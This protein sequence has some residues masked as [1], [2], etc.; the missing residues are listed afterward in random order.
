MCATQW[1]Y[2]YGCLTLNVDWHYIGSV[3]ATTHQEKGIITLKSICNI[4]NPASMLWTASL[5]HW[6]RIP[7][8]C[9]KYWYILIFFIC[10]LLFYKLQNFYINL[11]LKIIFIFSEGNR[12]SKRDFH[13]RAEGT[14][15]ET[16]VIRA[17]Y[18]GD[19]AAVHQEVEPR[20]ATGRRR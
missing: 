20:G 8:P 7:F 19:G 16:P 10:G 17:S 15:W 12:E 14:E 13:E 6:E 4:R 18:V 2:I 1:K 3:T 9:T 11:S 5:W